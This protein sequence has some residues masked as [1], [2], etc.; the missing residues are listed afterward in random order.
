M[1]D[2][3]VKKALTAAVLAILCGVALW[4]AVKYAF[5]AL[6]PFIF[7]WL[8]AALLQRPVVFLEKKTKIPKKVLSVVFVLFIVGAVFLIIFALIGLLIRRS[9]E[10]IARIT[11]WIAT[12][13]DD[14][15]VFFEKFGNF[16]EGLGFEYDG[17]V[18]E[19]LS[20]ALSSL[21][22][23]AASFVAG[24]AAAVASGLPRGL[25]FTAAL[26]LSSIYFCI[27]YRK[28]AD[29]ILGALPQRASRCVS[30]MKK[31]LGV[32]MTKYVRSYFLIFLV[33]FFEL[34]LGF[35]VYGMDGAPL[36]A[37]AIALIDILP[38]IGAGAALIPWAILKFIT[39]DAGTGV[40]LLALYGVTSLVRQVIEPRIVGK[41]IGLHPAASL[42]AMY[43][44]LKAVGV[45]GMIVA[46]LLFVI[47]RNTARTIKKESA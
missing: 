46:P 35:S 25:I 30:A 32:V 33:T 17:G 47:V 14:V 45:I 42:I 2:R 4:A 23:S 29:G 7:A 11:A 24:A 31:E 37:L 34:L 9:G 18:P 12:I 43:V 26:V 21:A 13:R 28:I 20:G 40:F 22:G 44:G 19:S 39:S 5:P 36:A 41:G 8:I 15:G 10:I 16:L 3:L 6:S 27:D 38:V 1:T